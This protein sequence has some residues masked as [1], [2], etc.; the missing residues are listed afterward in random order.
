[1]ADDF[2]AKERAAEAGLRPDS[3]G[4]GKKVGAVARVAPSDPFEGSGVAPIGT[5]DGVYYLVDTLGAL[6]AI[7]ARE[8]QFQ[9]T[10]LDIWGGDD[11]WLGGAFGWEDKKGGINIPWDKVGAALMRACHRLGP[12]HPATFPPR[13]TGIWADAEGKPLLHLGDVLRHHGGAQERAG[14]VVLREIDADQGAPIIERQVYVREPARRRPA[15]PCAPAEIDELRDEIARLWRFR[16]GPPGAELVLGWCCV[17]LLG[18]TVR[19]RPNL[20]VLGAAWSGK[21]SLVNVLRGLLPIH[22]YYNDVTKAG[23]ETGMTGRPGP[24]LVDE[25]AQGD[26]SEAIRL[27]DMMLPATGGDGTAGRRGAADGHGRSFNVLGA[28]CYAAIHPPPLKPEHLSRFTEIVL[29]SGD[30]DRST[31]IQAVIAQAARLGPAFFGR[32]LAGFARWD[33]NLREMRAALVA[34]GASPREAD[35]LGAVLAGWWILACDVPA[36][37]KDAGG[38]AEM[39]APYIRGRAGQRDDA[40]GRRAWQA[41]ASTQVL[42]EGGTSRVAIGELL[43]EAFA[44][45]DDPAAAEVARKAARDLRRYGIGVEELTPDEALRKVRDPWEDDAVRQLTGRDYPLRVAWFGRNQTEL[46]RLFERT[47]FAGEAWW[48][49]MEVLPGARRSKGNVR[50]GKPY[51]GGAFVL[52]IAALDLPEQEGGPPAPPD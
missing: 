37:P 8:I 23:I 45:S 15:R 31:E 26:R 29:L 19:W 36:T 46:R 16:D 17:A 32:V 5:T 38:C 30:R 40:A 9:S 48:R 13:Y 44:I 34:R 25:A 27:F 12:W 14:I 1:M 50:I 35:Q 18:A 6:R 7:R 47:D 24:L 39:A 41:L 51:S 21:S 10:L 2:D 28:V 33:G 3:T 20:L 22:L 4:G 42:R 49:A 11:S 43:A 52:P